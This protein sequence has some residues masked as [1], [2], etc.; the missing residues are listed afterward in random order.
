MKLQIVCRGSRREGLGHLL[1]AR[2]FAGAASRRHEV[3]VLALV[4]PDLQSLLG[5]AGCPVRL[6]DDERDVPALVS[7]FDPDAVVFDLLSLDGRVLDAVRRQGPVTA[8][9]SPVFDQMARVD[10]LFTRI[11]RTPPIPGVKLYAGLRYAIFGEQCRPI[12]EARYEQALA[13]PELPLA[14]SMGG[15]DAPNKTLSIVK[16]LVELDCPLTLWVLLGE[17]YAH[18]YDALAAAVRGAGRHEVI[19]AKTNRSMWH[20]L[21]SAAVAILAGG[22]TT[23]E[24][25]YAGLPSINVCDRPEQTAMLGELVDAKVALVA[26]VFEPATLARLQQHV[27][28]FNQNR[29]RLR[30]MRSAS[31]GLVDL[32]GP[33]R[34][35]DEL[36][37]L[38]AARRT[39][40]A[41]G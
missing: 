1:R 39:L 2:T 32:E 41:A 33:Q 21:S 14:I 4:E 10:A 28:E 17:G 22:L 20:V 38:V 27:R 25:V 15:A 40:R 24:A 18:S 26:G 3:E 16:A 31:A 5:D 6:L 35:L 7:T 30:S 12:D 8:S 9:L 23:V 13:A 37:Q 36:E 34:V 29:Q 11:A 19:L